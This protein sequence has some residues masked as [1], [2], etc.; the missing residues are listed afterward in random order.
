MRKQSTPRTSA[1][2]AADRAEAGKATVFQKSPVQPPGR[3][4]A[5][6]FGIYLLAAALGFAAL[7][8]LASRFSYFP[9][10]LSIT[11]A[12]QTIDLPFFASFMWAVSFI[13]YAPQMFILVGA[14]TILM[15]GIGLR[16]EGVTALFSVAG[17]SGLG[18]LIKL[19]VHRPRPGV[20][21]ATVMTTLNSYSFPSGHVLAYTVFFGF[22]FFLGCS[23]FKPS[24]VRTALLVV[25]G[26]L[27]ALI[28]LSR[29]YIGVHWASDV[30]GGYLLGSLWLVLTIAIYRWGK[31][32]F[33]VGLPLSPKSSGPTEAK[34]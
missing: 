20:D 1:P 25:L 18:E 3:W 31:T 15:F 33:M 27:V 16:W 4:R 2:T 23:L 14:I 13:G 10:D 5:R 12:V 29:I 26:G 19:L 22:L 8:V 32:R 11:R 17:A 30:T 7:A 34:L 9:I 28:G 24:I 21:L 6:F